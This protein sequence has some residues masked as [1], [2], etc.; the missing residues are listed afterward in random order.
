MYRG[1]HAAVAPPLDPYSS[2]RAPTP[3]LWTLLD[4]CPVTGNPRGGE[5]RGRKG[6][7]SAPQQKPFNLSLSSAA[8]AS[9]LTSTSASPSISCSLGTIVSR[10]MPGST[11]GVQAASARAAIIRRFGTRSDAISSTAGTSF[12]S[13]ELGVR[14]CAKP[15]AKEGTTA[16]SKYDCSPDSAVTM[17][18]SISS[19]H[20][21]PKP[22]KPQIS[23]INTTQ[24]SRTSAHE[25]E[26]RLVQTS[27]KWDQ[28][29]V[30]PS[31]AASCGNRCK[32]TCRTRQFLSAPS[33]SSSGSITA[34]SPSRPTT[35]MNGPSCMMTASRTLESS[36]SASSDR[37]GRTCSSAAALPSGFASSMQTVDSS[38]RETEFVSL[39]RRETVGKMCFSPKAGP[40]AAAAS[41]PR[42][43]AAT[44]TSDSWSDCSAVYIASSG[45]R[46]S[47][48]RGEP[49][50]LHA[51][52][53]AGSDSA[54]AM[55]TR[56]DLSR[57]HEVK[58]SLRSCARVASSAFLHSSAVC[59]SA[60][61]RTDSPS[62]TTIP[63]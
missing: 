47:S 36:S 63:R 17:G 50:S 27:S 24:S 46:S 28:N 26:A 33:R 5:E 10:A 38:T 31:V 61:T 9:N 60:L 55:R 12:V 13:R 30:G 45:P 35:S 18:S 57:V 23:A 4:A 39:A 42:S 16:R 41:A 21:C 52:A 53:T 37:H 49:S 15:A 3:S 48:D 8:S 11:S 32:I 34:A 1:R 56:H 6:L 40:S 22:C 2:S 62:S 7:R 59:L 54:A 20:A 29:S 58:H 14:I 25:S 19:A 43:A 44:L 51:S